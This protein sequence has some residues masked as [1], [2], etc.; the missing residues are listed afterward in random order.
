MWRPVVQ[1]VAPAEEPLSLEQAKAHLGV[2]TADDDVTIGEMVAAA[3]AAIESVTCTRLVTQTVTVRTDCWSDLAGRLPVAPVQTLTISYVD[4][5]GA[6]QVLDGAVYR[7]DL[8]GLEPRAVLKSGQAWPSRQNSTLITLT[9]VVGYGDMAAQ[10]PSIVAALKMMLGDL[11]AFRETAQVGGV[12]GK[13]PT[14]ASIDAL[15]ANFTLHL[16][17]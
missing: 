11:Y 13:I 9:A 12:A 14:S 5:E 3:R 15:L 8:E 7:A 17:A 10:H 1:T 16:I 2:D 4:T 6:D